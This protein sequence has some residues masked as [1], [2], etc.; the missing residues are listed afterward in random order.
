MNDYFI[1]MTISV[2]ALGAY[3]TYLLNKVRDLE[4]QIEMYND[5]ILTMAKELQSLGSKNVRIVMEEEDD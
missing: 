2:F 4:E 5:T 1:V 3:L